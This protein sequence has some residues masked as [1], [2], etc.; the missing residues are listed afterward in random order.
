MMSSERIRQVTGAC[1]EDALDTLLESARAKLS[2]A[3]HDRL[4]GQGG[5]P[6]LRDPDLAL[7][8]TLAA[9]H[10]DIGSAVFRRLTPQTG[11]EE[12][13]ARSKRT[14]L[15]PGHPLANRLAPVR[16]KYRGQALEVARSYWSN[17]L[18]PALAVARK[19]TEALSRPMEAEQNGA[20]VH[21]SVGHLAWLLEQVDLLLGRQRKTPE[22]AEIDYLVAVEA[23]LEAHAQP[24]LR[25]VHNAQQLLDDEL[26]PL[27]AE[28]SSIMGS[29]MVAQDL[30]DDLAQAWAKAR[31]LSRAVAIV[32]RVSNDFVGEDLRQANLDG[33]LLAG[34]RWDASTTWPAGWEPL[35]RRASMPASEEQGVL[36]IA[37]EPRDSVVPADA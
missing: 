13:R 12:G 32:R 30:A 37:A 23:S 26:A 29:E 3:V 27:L 10:R 16:I 21:D 22:P 5:I 17:D 2:I 14:T 33:A 34:I 18:I 25:E 11:P 6:E 24:L 35:I 20:Q 28:A 8:R 31:D 36:I 15:P 7:D 4:A 9:V 19:I 1:S